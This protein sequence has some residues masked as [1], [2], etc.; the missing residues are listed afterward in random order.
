MKKIFLALIFMG[1]CSCAAPSSNINRI[2]L[3][4]TKQQVIEVMGD[5]SSISAAK[6]NEYL[7]YALA[8]TSH[9][10]M[11]NRTTP[12]FIRLIDGKV[13]AYGRH[14]D[15]GTTQMTPQKII[16]EQ[17]IENKSNLPTGK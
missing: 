4:M 15:F 2:S 8:E 16:V 12:Y 5:P 10:V 1:L 6:G 9:D 17:T 3:G 14:G 13:D 7:N 11:H